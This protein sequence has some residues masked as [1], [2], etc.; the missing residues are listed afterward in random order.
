[1]L[2]FLVLLVLLVATS[3]GPQS[4]AQRPAAQPEL[5]RDLVTGLVSYRRTVVAEGVS[6]EQL[7]GRALA[8][9]RQHP[10]A[11]STL[12][13][14]KAQGKIVAQ[15]ADTI[16]VRGQAPAIVSHTLTF[17]IRADRF[18]YE[19]SNFSAQPFGNFE[20]DKPAGSRRA[21]NR[22]RTSTDARVKDWVSSLERA[23]MAK[24]KP[25]RDF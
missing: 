10:P 8:W 12:I 23:M 11:G 1:M 22:L 14:D 19:F 20:N 17:Y 24:E 16:A 3:Y 21:W 6:Q 9:V 2:R 25:S 13:A 15:S 5:P 7:Y 18:Q 4:Y